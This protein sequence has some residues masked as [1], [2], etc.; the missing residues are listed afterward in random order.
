METQIEP[1]LPGRASITPKALGEVR[2]ESQ[3]VLTCSQK[4]VGTV[5]DLGILH[6]PVSSADSAHVAWLSGPCTRRAGRCERGSL[7][8]P[9]PCTHP[10]TDRHFWSI[11]HTPGTVLGCRDSGELDRHT[12][13][14]GILKEA[15]RHKFLAISRT[16]PGELPT[17]L[18]CRADPSS[19][20]SRHSFG[21]SNHT[22]TSY[23]LELRV[24]VYLLPLSTTPGARHGSAG[25]P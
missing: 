6:G 10:F 19:R 22:S 12:C 21:A 4:T 20:W 24:K 3:G 25:V 13:G 1:F 11:S 5:S 14:T 16:D 17:S 2:E 15:L 8:S 7:A 23:V 9:A 18:P